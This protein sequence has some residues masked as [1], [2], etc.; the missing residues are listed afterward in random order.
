[1]KYLEAGR[2]TFREGIDI[3][4]GEGEGRQI[5]G[6]ALIFW[7]DSPKKFAQYYYP[8]FYYYQTIL[9]VGIQV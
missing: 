3:R 1:M 9:K 2:A 5:S 7:G 6:D 8:I 4:G